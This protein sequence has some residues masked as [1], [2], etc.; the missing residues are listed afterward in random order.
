MTNPH[1]VTGLM[2]K[3]SEL[4]GEV[5]RAEALIVRL[6]GNLAH[7]DATLALFD[8]AI[9]PSAIPTRVKREK[10]YAFKHGH[11]R[12]AILG[13]LRTADGPMTARAIAQ[14]MTAEGRLEVGGIH[15]LVDLAHK[16][17]ATL[18]RS[19]E[20]LECGTDEEGTLTWRVSG[21]AATE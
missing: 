1:V 3:R 11:F 6:R 10:P 13:V 20:G 4:A 16:I 18:R 19:P 17:R 2:E 5:K 8:P 15:D 9:R 7:L 21:E 14:R 12:R